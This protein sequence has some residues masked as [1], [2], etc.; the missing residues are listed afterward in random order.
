MTPIFSNNTKNL[1]RSVIIIIIIIKNGKGIF[2][3]KKT[4]F[5]QV[6]S[7][8]LFPGLG[9]GREKANYVIMT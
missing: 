7:Q 3:T 2:V 9:A 6:R 8:G 5:T 1:K 4:I